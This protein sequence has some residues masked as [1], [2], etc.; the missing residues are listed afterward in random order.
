ME[1]GSSTTLDGKGKKTSPLPR[2]VSL[3]LRLLASRH[4]GSP[5]KIKYLVNAEA[6]A[7]TAPEGWPNGEDYLFRVWSITLSSLVRQRLGGTVGDARSGR[8][9][10]VTTIFSG[11]PLHCRRYKTTLL[12]VFPYPPPWT[13]EFLGLGLLVFGSSA[14]EEEADQERKGK[15]NEELGWWR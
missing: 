9:S 13:S 3:S 2:S 7:V 6:A 5:Q 1:N 14:G 8:S 10:A 11:V 4:C 12:L 15:I